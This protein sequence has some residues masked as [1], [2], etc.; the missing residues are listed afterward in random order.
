MSTTSEETSASPKPAV[1]NAAPSSGKVVI[2]FDG[3]DESRHAI[4]VAAHLLSARP[5][6]VVFVGPMPD[7]ESEAFLVGDVSPDDYAAIAI[8]ED[9]ARERAVEGAQ[10]AQ[11][12]GFSAEPTNVLATPAW[13]GIVD[14]AD[15]VDAPVIVVGSRGLNRLREDL[16]GSTSHELALHAGRPVLIVPPEKHS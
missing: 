2:A 4:G 10:L 9:L 15:Q 1:Q 16:K 5:A 11:R 3:S 13:T 6:V 7:D 14:T 8:D 12:A